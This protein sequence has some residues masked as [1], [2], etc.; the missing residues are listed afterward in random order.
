M[1]KRL[2]ISVLLKITLIAALIVGGFVFYPSATAVS[3]EIEKNFGDHL[4]SLSPDEFKIAYLMLIL[5][6]AGLCCSAAGQIFRKTT[7]AL[8]GAG[9]LYRHWIYAQ[10]FSAAYAFTA[11]YFWGISGLSSVLLINMVLI[12]LVSFM[13]S[14]KHGIN[15][16]WI[17]KAVLNK[18]MVFFVLFLISLTITMQLF[19]KGADIKIIPS[20][21]VKSILFVILLGILMFLLLR[22]EILI[23]IKGI[24]KK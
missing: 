13:S 5:N 19:L 9:Y 23:L 7:I 15:G 24:I 4:K 21:F 6:F 8:G 16:K 11:I 12:A 17:L 22:K 10:F 3:G 2:S 1:S 20:L 18:S 14:Q